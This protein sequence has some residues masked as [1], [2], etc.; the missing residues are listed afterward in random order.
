[1]TAFMDN[2]LVPLTEDAAEPVILS[3]EREE[4]PEAPQPPEILRNVLLPCL[5]SQDPTGLHVTLTYAQT[6]DGKIAG[7]AG[8]QLRISGKESMEMTHWMRTM[9]DAILIGIGTALNDNPQLNGVEGPS[10]YKH[11]PLI[12]I[13]ARYLPPLPDNRPRPLPTPVILDASLRLSPTCKLLDNFQ[14]G[15]GMRPWIF[16]ANNLPSDANSRRQELEKRGAHVHSIS[17]DS[18]GLRSQILL[19][20]MISVCDREP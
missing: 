8:K 5:E 16:C 14:Q 18:Q 13:S 3:L 4:Q 11:R 9:H 6:L 12:D 19:D 17:V 20:P 1:M 7:K 15:I 2:Y 10:L